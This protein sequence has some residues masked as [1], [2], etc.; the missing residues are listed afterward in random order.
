MLSFN[1]LFFCVWCVHVDG[2]YSVI[3]P[4]FILPLLHAIGY[5]PLEVAGLGIRAGSLVTFHFPLNQFFRCYFILN[6]CWQRRLWFAMWTRLG[7]GRYRHAL[8]V[9][10]QTVPEHIFWMPSRHILLDYQGSCLRGKPGMW[11]FYWFLH[12]V[13]YFLFYMGANLGSLASGNNMGL[14]IK[15]CG[16]KDLCSGTW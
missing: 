8:L 14:R 3:T 10:C 16:K 1:F 11:P 2:A 13:W 9:W 7:C 15:Y 12:V 5:R 4:L 6:T